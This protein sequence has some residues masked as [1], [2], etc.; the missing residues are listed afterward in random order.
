MICWKNNK[1]STKWKGIASGGV[2]MTGVF[3]LCGDG[4]CVCPWC[5]VGGSGDGVGGGRVHGG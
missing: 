1:S 2:A 3:A 4:G 5:D